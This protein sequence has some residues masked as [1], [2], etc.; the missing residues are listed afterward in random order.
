[1][2]GCDERAIS[3]HIYCGRHVV[4]AE[5]VA[6]NKEI[7]AAATYLNAH[8]EAPT[9]VELERQQARERFQKRMQRGDFNQLLDATTGK[10]LEQA[11]E[12]KA[13]QLEVGALR[14][15]IARTISEETDAHRM[16]LSIARLANAISRLA[17][18]EYAT[19]DPK[20]VAR[21]G[22]EWHPPLE[23]GEKLVHYIWRHRPEDFA[24]RY[25]ARIEDPA[26]LPWNIDQHVETD[27]RASLGEENKDADGKY[28]P[29]PM[30][31]WRTRGAGAHKRA[32]VA[33]GHPPE[34]DTGPLDAE[35]AVS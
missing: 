4:S 6:F 31:E 27:Y 16:S 1:M 5:G 12:V 34:P 26:S 32:Q 8:E 10:I 7:Q 13:Y 15:A 22:A 18:A 24:E 23:G 9:E 19:R 35:A 25:M 11:A 3:A 33:D 29:P 17:V 14:F 30:P 20:P 2:E 28:L 21:Y